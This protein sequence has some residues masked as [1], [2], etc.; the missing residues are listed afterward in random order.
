MSA[1]GIVALAVLLS[2]VIVGAKAA[3]GYIPTVISL[4]G[5][6]SLRRK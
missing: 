2:L 1:S 6:G 5:A 4:M 3:V